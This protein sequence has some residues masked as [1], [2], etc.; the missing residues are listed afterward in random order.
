M[1]SCVGGKAN[2]EQL[3][4]KILEERGCM[5]WL[6]PTPNPWAREYHPH[7]QKSPGSLVEGCVVLIIGFFP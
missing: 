4:R 1:V 2:G 7:H 6:K 5:G 3:L